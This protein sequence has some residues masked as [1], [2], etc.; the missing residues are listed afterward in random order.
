MNETQTV[1]KC[2]LSGCTFYVIKFN[3]IKL[4][5][6][7]QTLQGDLGLG[8]FISHTLVATLSTSKINSGQY[9]L[10]LI[11]IAIIALNCVAEILVCFCCFFM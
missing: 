2:L 4:F 10:I 9:Q 3:I 1:L 6:L 11:I 8:K 7:W 5:I